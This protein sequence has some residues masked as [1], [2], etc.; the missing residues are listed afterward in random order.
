[1]IGDFDAILIHL[2]NPV[3]PDRSRIIVLKLSLTGRAEIDGK[4]MIKQE[5]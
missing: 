1:M 2:Q 5:S 4:V 3:L